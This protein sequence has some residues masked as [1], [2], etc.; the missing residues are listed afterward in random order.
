MTTPAPTAHS[1]QKIRIGDHL[2]AAGLIS[3]EQLNQALAQQKKTGRRLGYALV[4][5]NIIDED[6]LLEFLS[7]QL[8]LEYVDLKKFTLDADIV[9]IIPEI[10]ARRFRVIALKNDADQPL[11][12]MADPT[13]IYAFDEITRILKRPFQ[14]ALVK[15]SILLKAI[16]KLY[17]HT[18]KIRHLAQEVD[19][20][21]G[22]DSEFL[23]PIDSS[24]TDNPDAP[25]IQLLNTLFEDAVSINVS[26]IHIEPEQENTRIRFR[27]DGVLQ[28]QPPASRRL[29]G[30]L[31]SRLKLMS[32]LDISE[33]RLPQD[34]R[35]RVV[36]RN[37]Q[38]DIRLSTM[39]MQHGETAVMRLLNQT[40]GIPN[41]DAIGMDQATLQRFRKTIHSPHGIVLVT[42]PTGSGKTTTLYAALKDLNHPGKKIITVEDPVEYQI[43]GIT[44]VQVNPKIDLDFPRVLRS[45]LRQDPDIAL[46]GEMRDHETMETALRTA[47]TGHLVLSTLHT[48][49][50]ISTVSRLL[51]MGAAPFMIASSLK[52]ILAQRLIRKLCDNCSAPAPLTDAQQALI[53]TTFGQTPAKLVFKRSN[54]CPHCNNTGY[55]GRT[56]VSEFIEINDNLLESLQQGDLQSFAHLANLQ[57]GYQSLGKAA[58]KLALQGITSFEEVI[59]VCFGAS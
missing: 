50:A 23:D 20:Q 57:P 28:E 36:V 27:I 8:N 48:N 4:E 7:Q 42:G 15:E 37:Q 31:V 53:V 17:R 16:D 29:A 10:Q 52:G 40:A 34:G 25:L 11:I 9:K 51:D 3:Q 1:T 39:P 12:G 24:N 13:D 56:S 26:D 58:L 44:Q 46:I 45:L 22:Q 32:G 47:M 49:D 18:E 59:R 19:Q 38:I 33:K 43:P 35:F 41:L 54:G 55:M 14:T 6:Q 5:L 21:L 30:A 2:L